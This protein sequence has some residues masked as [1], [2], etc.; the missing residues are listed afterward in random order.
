METFA[1]S[2]CDNTAFDLCRHRPTTCAS[3]LTGLDPAILAEILQFDGSET[4]V[5]PTFGAQQIL[6]GAPILKDFAKMFSVRMPQI[7]RGRMRR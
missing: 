5:R 7:L 6:L 2:A 1:N 4:G 3:L